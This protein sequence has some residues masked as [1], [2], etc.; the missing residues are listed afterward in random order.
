MKFVYIASFILGFV[1]SSVT[2]MEKNELIEFIFEQPH[3]NEKILIDEIIEKSQT[4]LQALQQY[5]QLYTVSKKAQ[6]L[7]N[8]ITTK[9]RFFEKLLFKFPS[10]YE[11]F[12]IELQNIGKTITHKGFE[13]AI[14]KLNQPI[15]WKDAYKQAHD[16]LSRNR[17]FIALIELHRIISVTTEVNPLIKKEY[18]AKY[19]DIN[20]QDQLVKL[21]PLLQNI[22]LF[23]T[24]FFIDYYPFF[25]AQ[26][27]EPQR[28]TAVSILSSPYTLIGQ[29][30]S[31]QGLA[32]PS[33]QQRKAL[34][35]DLLNTLI[36][37]KVID[38]DKLKSLKSIQPT[39]TVPLQRYDGT[40]LN[41][42][43]EYS[44]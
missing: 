31:G 42:F 33:N 40:F 6:M 35:Q 32:H 15:R 2:C 26:Q 5:E 28:S 18:I 11:L 22:D 39:I 44:D 14:Y 1:A 24:Y 19:G 4:P 23:N 12:G 3:L 30:V 10:L 43:D 41:D 9:T 21:A 37:L 25:I 38:T 16:K 27:Q 17:Y 7:F 8:D 29:L 34:S 36:A 20:V 13:D